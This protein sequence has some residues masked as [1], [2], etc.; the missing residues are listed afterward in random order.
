[1]AGAQPDDR[2]DREAGRRETVP[3]QVE[4]VAGRVETVFGHVETVLGHIEITRLPERGWFRLA[5]VAIAPQHRGHGFGLALVDAAVAEARRLG[6]VGVDLR[7][8]DVNAAAR[9]TYRSAGFSDIGRDRL[10][11][12]LRWMIK[13]FKRG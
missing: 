10:Q 2:E 9:A 1:M 5:R 7:V 3:G 12:D 8:F 11:P 13:E 6:A 4:T